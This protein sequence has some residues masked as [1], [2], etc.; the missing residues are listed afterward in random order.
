MG[1]ISFPIYIPESLIMLWQFAIV[2]KK[3]VTESSA[4]MASIKPQNRTEGNLDLLLRTTDSP[5]LSSYI[6]AEVLSCLFLSF[7]ILPN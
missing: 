6:F 4:F 5:C 7:V 1:H 2:I 3:N